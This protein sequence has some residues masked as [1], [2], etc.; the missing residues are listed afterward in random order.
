MGTAG[1]HLRPRYL[2]KESP[3][4]LHDR[5][6]RKQEVPLSGDHEHG[7]LELPEFSWGRRPWEVRK[8]FSGVR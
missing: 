8:K 1:E 5:R 2:G 6:A 3:G 7:R 4:A